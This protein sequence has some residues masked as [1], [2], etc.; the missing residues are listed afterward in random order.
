[1]GRA[2]AL[3]RITAVGRLHEVSRGRFRRYA[4]LIGRL[5]LAISEPKIPSAPAGLSTA[6]QGVPWL[7]HFACVEGRPQA[8]AL[9]LRLEGFLF[10]APEPRKVESVGP[11]QPAPAPAQLP[12][13]TVAPATAQPVATPNTEGAP[14]DET[15]VEEVANAKQ[16]AMVVHKEARIY[17]GTDITELVIERLKK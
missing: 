13:N 7:S 9:I 1:M 16:L 11:P 6:H 5:G 14:S 15:A 4:Y 17:G 10:G 2:G 3:R 8:G 12:A